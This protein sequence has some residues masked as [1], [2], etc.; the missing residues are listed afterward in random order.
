[1]Q[2][3]QAET[4]I[5]AVEMARELARRTKMP[6]VWTTYSGICGQVFP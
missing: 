6:V 2:L 5:K 1:M 3:V 4:V